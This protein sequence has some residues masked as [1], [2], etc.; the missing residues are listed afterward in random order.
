M[1]KTQAALALADPAQLATVETPHPSALIQQALASQATP[2]TLER[3][4]GLQ[5]RWEA[6]EARRAYVTAMAGFKA[7]PP[8]I[9]KDKLV[10]F[11]GTQYRHATLGNVV[12]AISDGLSRHG[13][14]AA[15]QTSQDGGRVSVTCTI[16]HERGHSESTTL[17]GAPDDSGKKNAIQQIGS[18]VT[19]LQRY[20]LLALT[21]LATYEGDDDGRGSQPARTISDAEAQ[22]LIREVAEV[23]ADEEA[24]CQFLKVHTLHDLTEDGAVRARHL[25]EQKRRTLAKRLSEQAAR[26]GGT[27]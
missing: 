25:L 11:T 1:T 14:S 13:L 2:E 16:T 18:T 17:T 8:R 19:Y 21:G 22:A 23:G 6:N 10:S 3:L 5:E 9:V 27:Q 20:T 12:S 4:M 7:N 24:F 15:W 26:E